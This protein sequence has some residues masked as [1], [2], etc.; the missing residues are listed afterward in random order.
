L[1]LNDYL[2]GESHAE[3]ETAGHPSDNVPVALAI[4]GTRGRAGRDILAAI[5]IGYELYARLQQALDR[6]PGWDGVTASGVVVPAIAGR[7]ME[8]SQ[9]QLAHALALGAS[10]AATPSIVR[11]GAISAAKS[12]A[13]AMVA[14]SGVQAA[15]LAEQGATGPLTILDDARG[16]RGVL[17]RAKPSSL[18]APFPPDG[19]IMRAHVKAY[20]CVNTGQ[21]A[22]A[23]A[24]KLHE[25]IGGNAAALSRIEITMADYKV[26]KRHQDDPARRDPLSREAADHSFPFVVA[27]ALL[28]GRFGAEQFDN[29]RWR[30]DSVRALMSRIVMRRDALWNAR[31]PGSY[32]CAIVATDG[33]GR[34]HRV[35]VDYPPGYSRSGLDEAIVVDK[36]HAVTDRVLGPNAR[37]TI[38]DSVME[39]DHCPSPDKL[40]AAIATEETSK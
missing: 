2:I 36:F 18:C 31:A 37:A 17:V 23:A 33:H 3:P 15:L 7:L 4:G 5:A 28:D 29:E 26:T 38:V 40:N 1:D 22:V 10:R 11:G 35:E 34:Q 19:A 25:L 8:L 12:L 30:D 27:V 39:F 32:P 13:N 14:Q 16:L 24:L 20:P 21:S 9:Q 6:A